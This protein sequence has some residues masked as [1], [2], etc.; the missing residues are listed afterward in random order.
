M[1]EITA[2]LQKMITVVTSD[3]KNY[4]GVLSGVDSHTLNICLSS[5]RD[6]SGRT[7]NK[8]FLNGSNVAHVFSTEKAFN[9]SALAERLERVFP[10]MVRVNEGAG[11]I[12]VMDRIRVSEKGIVEG[13]GPAAERVQ[14]VYDEFVKAQLQP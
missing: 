2:Q 10:R 6:D 7:L 8:L 5:A 1:E 12:V 13:T 11:I 9:L 3:G 14:K 4:T